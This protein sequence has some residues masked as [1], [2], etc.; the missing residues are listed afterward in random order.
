MPIL[1]TGL[2]VLGLQHRFEMKI[3]T[4]QHV[5]SLVLG[6]APF[7]KEKAV[8]EPNVRLPNGDLICRINGRRAWGVEYDTI[9]MRFTKTLNVIVDSRNWI[10]NPLF[11]SDCYDLRPSSLSINLDKRGTRLWVK[12]FGSDGG[13]GYS[14][15]WTFQ[16][17]GRHSRTFYQEN[18]R[19]REPSN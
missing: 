2:L 18:K 7:D 4:G 15:V 11:F 3:Q 12:A 10:I 5:G 17:S 16:R 1:L 13:G 6:L 14:V 9:P 19:V 8:I